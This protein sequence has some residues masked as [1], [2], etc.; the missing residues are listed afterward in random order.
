MILKYCRSEKM[1][2][3]DSYEEDVGINLRAHHTDYD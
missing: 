2:G 3:Q 1:R